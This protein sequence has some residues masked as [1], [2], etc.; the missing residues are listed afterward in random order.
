MVTHDDWMPASRRDQAA[1]CRNWI[2]FL[3][4]ERRAAWG[5]PA[6]RFG[7]LE[8]L[9]TAAQALLRKSADRA[10]RTAVVTVRVEAA[11]R[12]MKGL[13]RFFKNHYFLLPPLDE[14]DLAS[15]GLRPKRPPGPVPV[16]G[17]A[18]AASLSYPGG[19]HAVT[20][21]LGPMAGT[22]DPDPRGGWGCELYL[23][24]MPPG[25][26]TLEQAASGKHYLREPPKSGEGLGFF[27]FT[28]R[29]KERILFDTEDAGMTA[30]VCCRYGNRR[31]KRGDWGPVASVVIP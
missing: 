7:E 4:A 9:H 19:P 3:T 27:S 17:G 11:F 8:N 20:A 6:D 25:G 21:H 14:S 31:G 1:M 12:A 2:G 13:M 22:A 30:Y 5:I 10:E 28:R 23:G 26:A 24:I 29:R 16:P 15:L 18:P